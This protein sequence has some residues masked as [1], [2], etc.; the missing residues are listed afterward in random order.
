MDPFIKRLARANSLA[1]CR[2][3]VDEAV[4]LAK[5]AR[6]GE[7]L[8]L[9]RYAVEMRR[10]AER[11]GGQFLSKRSDSNL[12]KHTA[13]RWRSFAAMS[14]KDFETVLTRAL[15]RVTILQS[16]TTSGNIEM[17]VSGWFR[18]EW[19]YPTRIITAVDASAVE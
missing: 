13:A 14:D 9:L 17:R 5:T 8:R 15:K 4:A 3:L 1:E 19:G 7:D 10:R 11:S 2:S 16:G 6:K 18:D 12:G